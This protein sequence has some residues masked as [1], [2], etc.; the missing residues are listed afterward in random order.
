[1][2]SSIIYFI[3]I[4]LFFL[5]FSGFQDKKNF[6]KK[7]DGILVNIGTENIQLHVMGDKIIRVEVTRSGESLTHKSLSVIYKPPKTIR[8]KVTEEA[9]SVV[10]GDWIN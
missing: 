8:W 3:F 5:T 1:M 2:R 6:I 4:P 10:L 7:S 9:G